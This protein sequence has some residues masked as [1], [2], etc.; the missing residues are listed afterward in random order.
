MR[1]LSLLIFSILA[2][3]QGCQSTTEVNINKA[4][5]SST[6]DLYKTIIFSNEDS[7][8]FENTYYDA[9]LTL[10]NKFP[11]EK[12]VVNIIEAAERRDLV[13]AY[14]ISTFPT[15]IVINNDDVIIRIEGEHS[16]DSIYKKLVNTFNK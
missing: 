12:Y 7:I 6:I 8:K 5:T 16:Q 4:T 15:L 3:V 1:K 2:L 9:L 11:N 13:D 14:N 10:K